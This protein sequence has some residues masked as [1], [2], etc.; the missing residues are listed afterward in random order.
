MTK[1]RGR[2][3]LVAA[4]IIVF[5]GGCRA[6][7]ESARR[8]ASSTTM[9][10]ATRQTMTPPAPAP[11][12]AA[13]ILEPWMKVPVPVLEEKLNR[14]FR[15]RW[16]KRP[17]R[18]CE[19]YLDGATLEVRE[20]KEHPGRFDSV[21][22]LITVEDSLE[23]PFPGQLPRTPYKL[24]RHL[25]PHWKGARAWTPYALKN[26]MRVCGIMAHVD[27]S[28]IWVEGG[29]GAASMSVR[30]IGVSVFPY[31]RDAAEAQQ[32]C[33]RDGEFDN[34]VQDHATVLAGAL[35]LLNP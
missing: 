2:S 29:L 34:G 10:S 23:R 1:R 21:G 16:P 5:V 4:F 8:S 24:L 13:P 20:D 33:I 27:H 25:F 14:F 30:L 26:S 9:A 35:P 22:L 31:R 7:D 28:L 12:E 3:T 17:S 19:L 18:E 15:C 6:R 11:R 32:R